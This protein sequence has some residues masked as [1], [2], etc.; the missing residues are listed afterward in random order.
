VPHKVVLVP[1]ALDDLR[2]IY[3]HVADAAGTDIADGY[4]SRIRTACLGLADFPGRG[5]P[6]DALAHGLRSIAFERRATIYYRVTGRTVEIV[7]V[8]HAGRDPER[9]FGED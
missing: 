9:T 6:R 5:T 8:F 7:H 2:S 3:D 1:E 4:Q